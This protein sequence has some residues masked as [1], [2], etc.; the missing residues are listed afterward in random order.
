M[1]L[2]TDESKTGLTANVLRK[3]NQIKNTKRLKRTFFNGQNTTNCANFQE[4]KWQKISKLFV[5]VFYVALKKRISSK[6][7]ASFLVLSN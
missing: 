6:I 1:T 3:K 7:R 4:L 2:H 5:Y